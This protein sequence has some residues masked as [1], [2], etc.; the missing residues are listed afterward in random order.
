MS[1]HALESFILNKRGVSW[2]SL[3]LP[4]FTLD[5]ISDQAV[6]HFKNWRQRKVGY[7]QTIWM[8]QRK[9]CLKDLVLSK[10]G[11]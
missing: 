11:T 10:M 1:G 9:I 4:G 6:E 5:N 2:D 3:P 8:S 7:R